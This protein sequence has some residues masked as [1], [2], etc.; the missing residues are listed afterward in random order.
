M[1]SP[2]ALKRPASSLVG[3]IADYF[4][5]ERKQV[6]ILCIEDLGEQALK[7][8]EPNV[9]GEYCMMGDVG[10]IEVVTYCGREFRVNAIAGGIPSQGIFFA[11]Y[12]N[13]G[14]RFTVG[15]MTA[16]Q[17]AVA[18]SANG[19]TLEMRMSGFELPHGFPSIAYSRLN[20]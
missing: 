7:V 12:S 10:P 20:P 18:G 15:M 11:H 6:A 3:S 16:L 13:G 14:G 5:G 19:V 4:L 9:A 17:D 8:F 2:A 1:L